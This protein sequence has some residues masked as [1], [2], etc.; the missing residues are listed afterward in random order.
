MLENMLS[1]CPVSPRG[2][3]PC[4]LILVDQAMSLIRGAFLSHTFLRHKPLTLLILE[5]WLP[6]ELMDFQRSECLGH[7]VRTCPHCELYS[8]ALHQTHFYSDF[9]S[10][11]SV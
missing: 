11:F 6:S 7:H 2:Q 9:K 5:V 1:S 4:C 3:Q 10:K 8:P